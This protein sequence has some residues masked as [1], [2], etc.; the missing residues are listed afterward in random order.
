VTQRKRW[1]DEI[2]GIEEVG[3]GGYA[4]QTIGRN[5]WAKKHVTMT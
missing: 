5:S 3:N 4:E 2:S 1:S